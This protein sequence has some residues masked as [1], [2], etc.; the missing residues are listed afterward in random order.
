MRLI[1]TQGAR[2]A[3]AGAVIGVGGAFLLRK[4]LASFLF[5]LSANDPWVLSIVPCVMVLVILM[6]SW[7]PA[8]RATKIDPMVALR[9]E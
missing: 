7:V 6:A 1:L 3:I 9:C 4:V 2:L 5:G 8:L